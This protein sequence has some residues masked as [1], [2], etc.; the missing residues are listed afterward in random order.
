MKKRFLLLLICNSLYGMEDGRSS[1]TKAVAL[2]NNGQH[3]LLR[4]GKESAHL[5]DFGSN[6]EQRIFLPNDSDVWKSCTDITHDGKKVIVGK[7]DESLHI[8]DTEKRQDLSTRAKHLKPLNCLAVTP[9]GTRVASGSQDNTIQLWNLDNGQKIAALIGHDKQVKC[10]VATHDNQHIVSGSDDTTIRVWDLKSLQEVGNLTGHKGSINCLA[11]AHTKKELLSGSNDN[12]VRLWNLSDNQEM[13]TLTGHQGHVNCLAVTSND[14]YALSGSEDK[15]V[16]VWDLKTKQV[17]AILQGHN[18]AINTIAVTGDSRKAL[19]V[20]GNNTLFIWNLEN[21]TPLAS[22]HDPAHFI[23]C[24]AAIKFN[25]TS[26][27]ESDHVNQQAEDS[28]HTP[29][30]P[31]QTTTEKPLT[32]TV[33]IQTELLETHQPATVHRAQQTDNSGIHTTTPANT[34]VSTTVQTE[35]L[36]TYQDTAM[37][38][39]VVTA[40][41]KLQANVVKE[42]HT[43]GAQAQPTTVHQKQQTNLTTYQEVAIQTKVVTA[44]KELQA[45][46]LR[47]AHTV[48][49]Q[50]QP[51]TGNKEQQVH[52]RPTTVH[53]RQQ[54]ENVTADK[55][56]QANIPREAR[57]VGAQVQPTTGNKEQQTD[58]TTYQDTAIQTEVVTADKELQVNIPKEACTAA[59]QVQP[60]TAHQGQQAHIQPT[61]VHQGQQTEVVTANKELQVNIPKEAHTVGAQVQPSTA[62][63]EQQTDLTTYQETTAQTEGNYLGAFNQLQQKLH[64][65]ERELAEARE[66]LKKLRGAGR[67]L[68]EAKGASGQWP[69]GPKP[70]TFQAPQFTT[71]KLGSGTTSSKT[72]DFSFLTQWF[73]EAHTMQNVTDEEWKMNVARRQIFWHSSKFTHFFP[74]SLKAEKSLSFKLDKPPVTLTDAPNSHCYNKTTAFLKGESVKIDVQAHNVKL[75]SMFSGKCLRTIYNGYDPPTPSSCFSSGG[76]GGSSAHNVVS[77]CFSSDERRLLTLDTYNNVRL[78]DPIDGELVREFRLNLGHMGNSEPSC[79]SANFSPDG[80]HIVIVSREKCFRNERG[81]L[82]IFNIYGR[83]LLNIDID[84]FYKL[85]KINSVGF[86]PDGNSVIFNPGQADAEKIDVKFLNDPTFKDFVEGCL[87]KDQTMLLLFLSKYPRWYENKSGDSVSF[88]NIAQKYENNTSFAPNHRRTSVSAQR[89]SE[90]FHSFHPVIQ[91]FLKKRYSLVVTSMYNSPRSATSRYT[92]HS[93]AVY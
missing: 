71:F 77:A 25:N 7:G 16:R 26:R 32:S 21:G 6:S 93:K 13:A 62:H 49:A 3:I 53:Q 68:A 48:G 5:Y 45:N 4:S 64:D 66:A 10:L 35:K 88:N 87:T 82:Y 8:I 72:D 33:G 56:L 29:A 36:T 59:T 1:L 67:G 50:A 83:R 46:I 23:K 54:T 40:N 31:M 61:T 9:N 44:N 75:M 47:E 43:V 90:I 89:L 86:S 11:L 73:S 37:Q 38:T 15:T 91:A 85:G 34:H 28:R 17:T 78:W 41:K 2:A 80:N 84:R 79:I 24:L 52:I 63:Q 57:A 27:R 81:H 12:T 30:E 51:T 69:R 60:S 22:F 58:L 74:L 70:T 92:S 18:F 76:R 39:E 14:N 55:G 42:T 65:T 20:A 19:S